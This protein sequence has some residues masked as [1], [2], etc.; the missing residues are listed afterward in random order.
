MRWHVELAENGKT[1]FTEHVDD[2][3]IA[4]SSARQLAAEAHGGHARASADEVERVVGRL[5]EIGISDLA[6]GID[7]RFDINE[8]VAIVV[9]GLDDADTDED[10]WR[11]AAA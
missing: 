3:G 5:A 7:R 2:D 1:L 11:C 9:A 8:N 6:P 10:C 4:L